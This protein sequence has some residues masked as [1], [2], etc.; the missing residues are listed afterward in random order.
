MDNNQPALFNNVKKVHRKKV[1]PSLLEKVFSWTLS[2]QR[3]LK[4]R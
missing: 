1:R 2:Q 3:K 4:V